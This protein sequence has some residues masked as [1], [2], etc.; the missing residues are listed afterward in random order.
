VGLQVINV[1]VEE[2]G[3]QRA[4]LSKATVHQERLCSALRAFHYA[5]VVGIQ[6]LISSLMVCNWTPIF[7]SLSNRRLRLTL[8]I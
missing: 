3:T 7:T 4:T 1:M 6:A 8:Y 5:L 2:G